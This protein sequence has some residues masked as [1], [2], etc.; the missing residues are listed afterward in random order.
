MDF[1]LNYEKGVINEM[2]QVCIKDLITR[3]YTRVSDLDVYF[4]H[5]KE[6][7]SIMSVNEKDLKKIEIG[8]TWGQVFD[9]AW[10][11]MIGKVDLKESVDD[12]YLHI[13]LSGEGLLYD[14]DLIPLKGFTPGSFIFNQ[15]Y[16][17]GGKAYY[18]LKTFLLKDGKIEIWIDA[19]C[20]DLFG[21]W[22]NS[23]KLMYAEI[24]RKDNKVE[25][26]YYDLEVLLS[27]LKST[28]D[29]TI[30]QLLFNNLEIVKNNLLYNNHKAVERSLE[31]TTKLLNVKSNHP[32]MITAVGHA[33]I[34]LAWLWPIRETKRKIVRTMSN[35]LYLL[36]KHPEMVF[37][38]SQPQQLIWLQNESPKTFDEIKKY[39]KSGQIE[40]VGGMYVEADTNITGE[41]SLVRQ[42]LYGVKY[43]EDNFGFKVKNLWLPDVFGYTGTLPQIIL[44]SGLE[45]FQTIKMSW[46]VMNKFPYHTFYWQG[47]DGSKILTHMPPEGN[48]NSDLLPVITKK[49]ADNYQQTEVSNDVLAIYGVGDGGGGPGDEHLERITRQ[50]SLLDFPKIKM[51][52][53]DEFFDNLKEKA[54]NIPI[55]NNELYLENHQGTYTSQSNIKMYNRMLE[56]KLKAIETYFVHKG[57][58]K[59]KDQLDTIW[60]EV[61]LYQFHDILPGSSIKRVYDEAIERYVILNKQ[62]ETML[63][64][65]N[66][67]YH[68]DYDDGVSV[69]NHNL[70]VATKLYKVNNTYHKLTINPLS[71][72]SFHKRYHQTSNLNSNQ[73]ETTNLII[74]FSENAGYINRIFSKKKNCELLNKSAN[75][76]RVYKDFG[77]AW[78]IEY[79]YQA[80]DVVLMELDSQIIRTYG[81]ITEIYNRYIFQSSIVDELVVIDKDTDYI[82]FNHDVDWND[83]NYMLRTSFDTIVKSEEAICDIQFGQIR[84]TTKNESSTEKG[85]LEVCA[86]H[87]VNLRDS[88]HSITLFNNAKYGYNIKNSVLDLNLLRS[89]NFPCQNGDIGKTK[90]QYAFSIQNANESLYDIDNFGLNFNAQYLMFDQE[91]LSPFLK[92]DNNNIEYSTIKDSFNDKSHI[93]RLYEKSGELNYAN[94]HFERNVKQ[95][96]LVNLVED[97]IEKITVDENSIN[98]MFTPYEIKTIQF[99][100]EKGSLR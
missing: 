68:N 95:A 7:V 46:S 64:E 18:P 83:L 21:S 66:S 14:Q 6:P 44:K 100:F 53:V 15:V 23:G 51:G 3:I 5:T 96:Y 82:T 54:N 79:H 85:Q 77:N 99:E 45:Y 90:Y 32:L 36:A 28:E 47:I 38:I 19:S 11:K 75:Q 29:K 71:T 39:V 80:Q 10:F 81:P 67:S 56:Q 17:E 87:W 35:V 27:V 92:I 94:L 12:L 84:R 63:K 37:V 55:Y 76:L 70:F 60:K 73:I 16:G 43:F 41:E 61:L 50:G 52:R 65:V 89:T 1:K 62:L 20:N 78:N 42:F 8:E 25:K 57:V 58:N 31:I 49:I 22:M 74:E 4:Y 2:I 98:L 34:D 72:N 86:H 97:R 93:I 69:Y 40:L 59:F 26:L 88:N 33:H 91:E 30:Y 9:C 13:D 24:V 48:Y